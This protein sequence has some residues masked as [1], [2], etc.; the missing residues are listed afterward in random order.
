MTAL[1][2][3]LLLLALSLFGYSSEVSV[4]KR[5]ACPY[6]GIDRTETFKVEKEVEQRGKK[7]QVGRLWL[8]DGKYGPLTLR[9]QKDGEIADVIA[10]DSEELEISSIMLTELHGRPFFFV[11]DR[12][13][14]FLIDLENE[15]I[16]PFIKPGMDVEYGEDALSGVMN[17]FQFFDD[18]NYLLGIAVSYGLFCFTISDIDHPKEL[19]RYSADFSDQGQPYFFL[20]QNV[21]GSWNGIVS[22][23]DTSKKSSHISG[24]Y[25]ETKKA[26]FLFRNEVL[27]LPKEP[28]AD[29]V[30]NPIPYVLLYERQDK[31]WVVDLSLGVLLKAKQA[32][33]FLKEWR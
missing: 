4:N 14:L 26:E 23:S 1:Y 12:Y 8:K 31:P 21:D 32:F 7:Y 29:P 15:K 10:P 28:Y 22:Q 24:F 30:S 13:K 20:E 11:I 19:R 27:S 25:T 2:L 16:S 6:D 3:G 5:D 18:G 9:V 17:G 33:Q